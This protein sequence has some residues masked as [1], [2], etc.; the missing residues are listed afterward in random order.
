MMSRFPLILWGIIAA[1]IQTPL[2]AR[3]AVSAPAGLLVD[4]TSDPMAMQTGTPLFSWQ[5]ISNQRGARQTAYEI[6]IA[7][8]GT[9][10]KAD[11]PDYWDSGKISSDQSASVPYSGPH[12]P[13]NKRFF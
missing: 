3:A 2:C 5:M 8:D 11:K 12:L 13:D 1:I 6:E 10:L 4:G 9:T 7:N